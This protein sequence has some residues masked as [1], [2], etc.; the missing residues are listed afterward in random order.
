[1]T[2]WGWW[3]AAGAALAAL[4]LFRRPL[5]ALCRLAVRSG[6]G[7]VFRWPVSYTPLRA[8]ETEAAVVCRLRL[9]KIVRG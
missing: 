2:G 6:L 7:L 3:A 9:E 5:G 4:A 1:M 8:P